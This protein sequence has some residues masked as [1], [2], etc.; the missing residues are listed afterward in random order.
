MGKITGTFPL[1]KLENLTFLRWFM[2]SSALSNEKNKKTSIFTKLMTRFSSL[3]M[4]R[5][6]PQCFMLWPKMNLSFWT[7][8]ARLFWLLRAPKWKHRLANQLPLT[9]SKFKRW[10]TCWVSTQVKVRVGTKLGVWYALI[11]PKSGASRI[12]CGTRNFTRTKLSNTCSKMA[13]KGASRSMPITM[14]KEKTLRLPQI[15]PFIISMKWQWLFWRVIEIECAPQNK[16]NGFLT[17]LA[18]LRN[19][20]WW[21]KIWLMNDLWQLLMTISWM[22]YFWR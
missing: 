8:S 22:I 3:A 9:T 13:L 10:V 1:Q 12:R 20:S 15:F 14:P 21:S 16:R 6:P 2:K 5:E 18:L 19:T 11:W 4:I 17:K 7:M